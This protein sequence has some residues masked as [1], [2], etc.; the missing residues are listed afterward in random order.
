[1][2]GFV[3]KRKQS[4]EH[5]YAVE[6]ISLW[7]KLRVGEGGV[8]AQDNQARRHSENK[9]F[10]VG[11]VVVA[12]TADIR[13]R[14][15]R[16]DILG[17]LGQLPKLAA[18][19]VYADCEHEAEAYASPVGIVGGDLLGL[20]QAEDALLEGEFGVGRAH[21]YACQGLMCAS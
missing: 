1:V 11:E 15:E 12:G 2:V 9:G 14:E 3:Y 21:W 6:R 5:A 17:R 18:Q 16:E 10:E 7:R 8:V 19:S 20:R 13:R 4:R